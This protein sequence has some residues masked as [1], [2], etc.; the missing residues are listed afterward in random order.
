MGRTSRS[1]WEAM[2]PSHPGSGSRC[3][4]RGHA[5]A[6]RASGRGLL[7]RGGHT[8]GASCMLRRSQ[9]GWIFFV[10][11]FPYFSAFRPY[12]LKS[13][14]ASSFWDSSPVLSSN[15]LNH[16]SVLSILSSLHRR[17]PLVAFAMAWLLAH[18]RVT[19]AWCSL[20][21]PSAGQRSAPEAASSS[22]EGKL[23]SFKAGWPPGDTPTQG[24][25]LPTDSD[26]D[27]AGTR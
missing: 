2:P 1:G 13:S 19:G 7:L 15:A 21:T 8:G 9:P 5:R 4:L 26:W 16:S 11:I 25:M 27:M 20:S 24:S 18:L 14:T 22:L 6:Q 10:L 17:P 12:C 23:G 3:H